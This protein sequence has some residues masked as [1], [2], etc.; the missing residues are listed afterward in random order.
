[1]K[2]N[3]SRTNTYDDTVE[4]KI[5]QNRN[6]KQFNLPVLKKSL[7]PQVMQDV[8]NDKSIVGLKFKI[9]DVIRRDNMGKDIIGK[10]IV[11]KDIIRRNNIGK[12]DILK[13][14]IER[15]NFKK[16]VRK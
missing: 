12:N 3:T 14:N 6:N 1:M 5:F 9:T 4:V 8:F 11:G 13:N 15:R 10:D 2:K 16:N 7:S